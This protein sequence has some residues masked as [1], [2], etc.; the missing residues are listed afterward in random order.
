MATHGTIL[1]QI[2]I[3]VHSVFGDFPAGHGFH[4]PLDRDARAY[5]GVDWGFETAIQGLLDYAIHPSIKAHSRL[6][7][8]WRQEWRS[9]PGGP[10]PAL[11]VNHR[12]GEQAKLQ[13]QIFVAVEVW[14]QKGEYGLNF[15]FLDAFLTNPPVRPRPCFSTAPYYS[16]WTRLP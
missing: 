4:R 3:T 5:C 1:A 11:V 16:S 10:S 7:Q 6:N 2:P 14:H 13:G 8:S 9:S 15:V 12:A